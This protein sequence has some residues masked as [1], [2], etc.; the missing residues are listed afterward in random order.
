MYVRISLTQTECTK[1]AITNCHQLKY[2]SCDVNFYRAHVCTLDLD[3]PSSSSYHL[4]QIFIRLY[5]N[6][7]TSSAQVLSAHGE[8]EQVILF[9]RSITTSAIT[10]LISNSPNLMLLYILT[11]PH[12][13][14]DENGA[15]V[16]QKDYKDIVSKRFPHHKLLTTGDL[17]LTE[18]CARDW[19]FIDYR[20][21]RIP[22]H[23]ITNCN[24]FWKMNAMY[25]AL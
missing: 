16:N 24:S 3:L 18:H 8:L 25:V 11:E 2:L 21:T 17:I 22:F 10:T 7:S 1:Y 9:V 14:C 6:L 20:I 23:H 5:I 13:L 4:Q 19:W 15:S 12:A